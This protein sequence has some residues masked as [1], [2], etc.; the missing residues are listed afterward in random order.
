MAEEVLKP[1]LRFPEFDEDWTK[2]T[3]DNHFSFKNTNSYSRNHLNYENGTVKN[4]HYGD[5]HTKFNLLFDVTNEE[6]PFINSDINVEK[7][8]EDNYIQNGDLVFADA[9]E[10][11]A[12]IGKSIEVINTN[13]EK[14]L[15]GLH[16]FLARKTDDT[17]ANGFFAFLLKTYK[18]RLEIMRIAQGTKVLGISKTRLGKI[19]LII[20]QSD[21]Q[22]KIANSLVSIDKRINLLEDKLN[23]LEAYKKS[24]L[25][26]IF[27]QNIRFKDNN[28]NDFAKWSQYTL[29]KIGNTYNGLTNKTK[30]DFGY[31]KPYVQYMQIFK[32][33]KIDISDFGLVSIDENENQSKVEYGDVLFTTSS[34]TP[35]EVGI[36]SVILSKVKELYL[37]SFSFGYR[38]KSFEILLPEF[39]RYFFRSDIMRKQIT[40]LAQGSTR[41]NLSK[42]SLM[43]QTIVVP[44]INEQKKIASFLSKIDDK[45]DFVESQIEETKLFKQSLLQKMFI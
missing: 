27:N 26:K 9:S 34:E 15:A 35:N 16:T 21:E 36:S 25:Q 8:A 1:S 32:D 6:V 23:A 2:T 24:M 43:K 14:I 12:D 22:Q 7:I 18:A 10:D 40:R 4:I 41:Y 44:T 20:P 17:V 31:G 37:N 42:V 45:I 30:V 19:P 5:I 33:S 28:G 11:Y 39:C 38:L 3:L 13:N 29:G